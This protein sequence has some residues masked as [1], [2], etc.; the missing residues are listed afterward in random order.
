MNRRFA[1]LFIMAVLSFNCVAYG[2]TQ[3]DLTL[4]VT[5]DTGQPLRGA[6]ATVKFLRIGNEM[7]NRGITD[8]NGE[9]SAHTDLSVGTF[10]RAEKSGYYSAQMDNTG[11]F[12]IPPGTATISFV[13]PRVL[14]P[15]PLHV[16]RLDYLQLPAQSDWVG[17][18]LEVADWLAPHGKGKIPDIRFRYRRE[19][20]GWKMSEE[21]MASVRQG[22][23]DST[24]EE[25]RFFYGKWSGELEVSFPNPKEGV[26]EEFDR[27]WYYNELRLPHMAPEDGYKPSLRYQA[28]TYEPRKPERLVGY[29]LRTRVRLNESGEIVSANYAKIYGD[30]RFDPRGSVSF[31]YYYNP[32]GNDRNLEFDPERNLFPR[33]MSGTNVMNP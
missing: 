29:F 15:A 25:L 21:K 16:L 20:D 4:R 9:F 3:H 31:W 26:A 19:F 2:Q 13:L 8:E 1:A 5:D 6:Q 12:Y 30:I 22:N 11:N 27:Y 7:I 17:Y 24:E 10:L 28:N 23:R 14:Q 33:T 18:D 32:R